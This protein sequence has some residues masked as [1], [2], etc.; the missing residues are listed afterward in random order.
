MD[1]GTILIIE[2]EIIIAM[3]MKMRLEANGYQVVSM[4]KS[5]EDG[6]KL[7]A[8]LRPDLILTEIIFKGEL[9]GINAVNEIKKLYQTSVIYLTTLSYL[10]SDPRIQATHPDGFIPKPVDDEMLLQ[11]IKKVPLKHLSNEK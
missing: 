7:A 4:A 1:N 11:A 3:E 8:K 5:A 6:V 2:E 9:K 10:E